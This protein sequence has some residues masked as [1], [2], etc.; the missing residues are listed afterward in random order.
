MAESEGTDADKPRRLEDSTA[1]YLEKIDVQFSEI[2]DS[3]EKIILIE[4]VLTEI[5]QRI[6]SAACDKRTNYLIEQ[7]CFAADTKNLFR[8][9]SRLV[10]YAL[11]LARNRYSS[12]VLQVRT[13]AHHCL[14]CLT[15]FVP[16][17]LSL[18]YMTTAY[19]YCLCYIIKA[20]IARMC[21]VIKHE[22]FGEE[23]PE[24]LLECMENLCRPVMKEIHW[25][26]LEQ[27]ATHVV[28]SMLS[29]L[30]GIPVIAEKKVKGKALSKV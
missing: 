25:L 19:L 17:A 12:H 27:S 5:H 15:V 29:F 16:L 20:A 24:E 3:E 22:E 6:A 18:G 13:M 4:N 1:E 23:N 21:Y 8:L 30:I 26:I 7:M 9:V 10:P 11:F 2:K 28:R 14:S